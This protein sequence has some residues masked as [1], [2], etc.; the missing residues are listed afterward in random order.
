MP[1]VNVHCIQ[2][3]ILKHPARGD[4]QIQTISVEF[5]LKKLNPEDDRKSRL[6]IMNDCLFAIDLRLFYTCCP[7]LVHTLLL[8]ICL[9]SVWLLLRIKPGNIKVHDQ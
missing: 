7:S 1:A 8:T 5:N 3:N 2:P 4:Q 6:Q 9:C